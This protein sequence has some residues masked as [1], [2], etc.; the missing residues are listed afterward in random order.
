MRTISLFC[1]LLCFF[2]CSGLGQHIDRNEKGE[3]VSLYFAS[4]ESWYLFHQQ[5]VHRRDFKTVESLTL[6]NQKVEASSIRAL[7]FMFP[8]LKY[9]TLGEAPEGVELGYH[10]LEAAIDSRFP[11]LKGFGVCTTNL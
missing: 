7:P 9:L 4:G 5:G 11:R 8:A 1:G 6:Q 2:C 10:A 3:I